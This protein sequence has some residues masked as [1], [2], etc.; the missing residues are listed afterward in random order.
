MHAALAQGV[1]K[2]DPAK[3]QQI[4]T[5]VCV[6]CHATDGNS[7]IPANPVLAGQHPEYAYKQLVNFKPQGGKPAERNNG[8]MAGMV[9]NLSDDDMKNLAAY[10][11]VQKVKPRAARDAT[12]AKQGESIYRGGVAGKGVPACAGC[13]APNG[14]GMP[15]QFPR[16]AG[17]HAEYT[18]AQ[19]KAFRSGQRANDAAQM[20][21]G[22]AAKMSDQEITAVSEYIAGLR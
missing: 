5:Q 22:V 3:A 1:I 11:A 6:A 7:T 9:A 4:V 19:L 8:V 20:M 13:H 2:G 15:A 18:S 16:L 21:R 14:A 17:Q 10:F 12:L